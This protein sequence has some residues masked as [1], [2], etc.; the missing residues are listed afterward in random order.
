[1]V[2]CFNVVLLLLKTRIQWMTLCHYIELVE[3]F[4]FDLFQII[5]LIDLNDLENK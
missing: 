2:M 5:A 4:D 3:Y 1:M